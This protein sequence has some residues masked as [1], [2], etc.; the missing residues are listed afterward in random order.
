M[1]ATNTA[2]V[3]DGL[4]TRY[5]DAFLDRL[6]TARYS[7]VTLCKKRRVLSAFSRW[8]MSTDVTLAHLDESAIASFMDR[9][10]DAPAARVQFERAV[11]GLFLAYLH[12]ETIVHLPTPAGDETAIAK[13][14]GRYVDYLRQ[15]RGLAKNSVL[16]Y[17]KADQGHCAR[18]R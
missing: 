16:V 3:S 1:K 17:G 9:L 11:L 4:P 18:Y 12:D 8:M 2:G 14:Y 13:I 10:T 5:I 15:D 6:R 7:E